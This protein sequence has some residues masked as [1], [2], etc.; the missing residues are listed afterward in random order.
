MEAWLLLQEAKEDLAL[1]TFYDYKIGAQKVIG[2][3][4]SVNRFFVSLKSI[5][6]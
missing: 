6:F 3:V 4:V 1:P 5:L 2:D